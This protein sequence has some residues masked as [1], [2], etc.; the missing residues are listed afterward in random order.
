MSKI[1]QNIKKQILVIGYSKDN[2]TEKAYDLAYKVGKII[3]TKDAILITGGLE[4]VME[5]ASKGSK[6]MGGLVVGIS[7]YKEK[8]LANRYCDVVIS[9][10]IGKARDF[11]NAYTADSVIIIGGGAGTLTEAT[12]AYLAGKKIIAIKGSGGVADSIS[13]TY[14]DEREKTKIIGVDTPQIAVEKAMI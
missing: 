1:N 8:T 11:I 2:C 14:L 3:G 12:A 6:E 10:G 5:A 9:T 13:D 7:P 4:G